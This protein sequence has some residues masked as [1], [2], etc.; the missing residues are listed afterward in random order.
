MLSHPILMKKK[1]FLWIFQVERC[2]NSTLL[3]KLIYTNIETFLL[4]SDNTNIE[5]FLL[6]FNN[7]IKCARIRNFNVE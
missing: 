5:T 1:I 6:N 4:N 7:K 3:F 2:F